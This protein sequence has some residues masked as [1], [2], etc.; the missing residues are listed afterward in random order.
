M[1]GWSEAQV[2]Y[3]VCEQLMV[4]YKKHIRIDVRYGGMDSDEE[5]NIRMLNGCEILITTVPSLNRNIEAGY[6]N[7]NR[8][9]SHSI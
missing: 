3:D 6:T 7:L 8:A 2:V 4:Y 9:M 1:A 5:R